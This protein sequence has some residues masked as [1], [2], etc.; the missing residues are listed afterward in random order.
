MIVMQ[1]VPAATLPEEHAQDEAPAPL[2][3]PRKERDLSGQCG[4]VRAVVA[5]NLAAI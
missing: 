4:A 1:S 3:M 5:F 2:V